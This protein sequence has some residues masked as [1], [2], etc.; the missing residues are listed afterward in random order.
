MAYS[1]QKPRGFILYFPVSN[2]STANSQIGTAADVPQ[3][4]DM[5]RA[6]LSA[7]TDLI[8]PGWIA[9]AKIDAVLRKRSSTS[10]SKVSTNTSR[11][12]DATSNSSNEIKPDNAD[13]DKSTDAA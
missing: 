9:P 6:D 4:T 13:A 11:L 8:D 7:N 3:T 1:H 12:P 5:K 10:A 2:D